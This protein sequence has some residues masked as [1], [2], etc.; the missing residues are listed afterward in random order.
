MTPEEKRKYR[1]LKPLAYIAAYG[2]Q[3][4]IRWILWLAFAPPYFICCLFERIGFMLDCLFRFL[5]KWIAFRPINYIFAKLGF[6]ELD[7]KAHRGL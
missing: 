5:C 7:K 3:E 4:P 2:I 6:Y 1:W